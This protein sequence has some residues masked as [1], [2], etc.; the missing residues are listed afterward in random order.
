MLDDGTSLVTG[1]R[2]RKMNGKGSLHHRLKFAGQPQQRETGGKL[3]EP[4]KQV[5]GAGVV[6]G[7]P[8][9]AM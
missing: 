2:A 3:E 4:P 5:E 6:H 9:E 8:I 7:R 1:D